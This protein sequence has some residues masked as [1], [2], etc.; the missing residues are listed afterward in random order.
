M[1][2]F[3]ANLLQKTVNY[4]LQRTLSYKT[5]IQRNYIAATTYTGNGGVYVSDYKA[6]LSG[7]LQLFTKISQVK[8]IE[9]LAPLM[10]T[11]VYLKQK[12]T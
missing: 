9:E 12:L 7:Q 1:K 3:E 2:T 8:T 10:D 11:Y 6:L 5:K 4:F